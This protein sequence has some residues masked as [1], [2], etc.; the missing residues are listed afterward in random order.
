MIVLG[1][2]KKKKSTH[3][4][5]VLKASE[6]ALQGYCLLFHLLIMLSEKY[7]E[8]IKEAENKVPKFMNPKEKYERH[9]YYTRNLGEFMIYLFLC[10]NMNWLELCPYFLEESLARNIVWFLNKN[11]GLAYIEPNDYHSKYRLDTTFELSK[12]S[13]RLILFQV[14]FLKIM[15]GIREDMKRRYG[16]PSDEMSNSLL[17]LIKQIYNVKTWDVF[18]KMLDFSLPEHNWEQVVSKMLKDAINKSFHSRYHRVP[19]T[20]NEL[21]FIRHKKEPWIPPPI[22]WDKNSEEVKKLSTYGCKSLSFS[23]QPIEDCPC[24]VSIPII[25]LPLPPS[26]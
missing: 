17:L 19:Y 20:V 22:S 10:K 11:A 26:Y 4:Y 23:P 1:I 24:C 18:F 3:N 5:L 25:Y 8:I 2:Q 21:Y 13:L 14:S 12:T 7:P 16:Y 15:Q 6:K 9:K